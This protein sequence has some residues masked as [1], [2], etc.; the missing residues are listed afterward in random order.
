MSENIIWIGPRSSDISGDDTFYSSITSYGNDKYSYCTH[1]Q[2]R[3]TRGSKEEMNFIKKNIF[4][5]NASNPQTLYMLYDQ[6]EVE[7]FD[8]TVVKKIICINELQ[9]IKLLNSKEFSRSWLSNDINCLPFVVMPFSDC[10][11]SC[12]CRLFPGVSSFVVQ[13]IYSVGGSKTFLVKNNKHLKLAQKNNKP[14]DICIASP[15]I[16]NSISLNIHLLCNEKGYILFPYSTQI[17]KQYDQRLLYAG[18]NFVLQYNKNIHQQI[19]QYSQIIS[20]KL[21]NLG[22]KG[23][24]GIDF[25]YWNENLY[26]VEINPRFQGSTKTLNLYL[27]QNN[28][29]SIYRMN[30][31]LFQGNFPA[32]DFFDMKIPFITYNSISGINENHKVTPKYINEYLDDDG[33]KPEIECE[34]GVYQYRKIYQVIQ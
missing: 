12:L 9:I 15:Y 31:E 27:K 20:S 32:Y 26:F 10:N 1:K 34:D 30:I 4:E 23:I 5:L 13:N 21:I 6:S 2:K 28:Y 24:A 3:I 14:Y 33:W 16:K 8:K 18:S 22:Y 29:P 25:L 17:I 19:R 11:Y 7:Q